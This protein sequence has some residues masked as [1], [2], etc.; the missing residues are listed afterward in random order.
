MASGSEQLKMSK[1]DITIELGEVDVK[2]AI[3][4]YL[5][6]YSEMGLTL[7]ARDIRIE[8]GENYE[9]RPGVRPQPVF[10][11]ATATVTRGTV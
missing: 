5:N 11:K 6:R 4:E 10:K 7:T 9:D 3:A 2:K 1:F 8:V